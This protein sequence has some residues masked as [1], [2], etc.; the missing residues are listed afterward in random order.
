MLTLNILELFERRE[1]LCPTCVYAVT[2]KG[3]DGEELTGCFLGGTLREL[4]FAVAECTA[5]I[6][7]RLPRPQR[8][9]GFVKP[10]PRPAVIKV[11]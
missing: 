3:F 2:Q 8:V 7:R 11:A 10:E 1:A 5:Y 6:D 4:K 9:A